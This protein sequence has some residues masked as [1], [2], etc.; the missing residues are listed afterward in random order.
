MIQH[1]NTILRRLSVELVGT[2]AGVRAAR[3]LEAREARGERDV[4]HPVRLPPG[5]PLLCC[6]SCGYD[7][8]VCT[9]DRRDV[10]PYRGQLLVWP[11]GT[12]ACRAALTTPQRREIMRSLTPARPKGVRGNITV[13]VD[14]AGW[15]VTAT[16]DDTLPFTATFAR[17]TED[18]ERE[19]S[20]VAG[21]VK[22]LALTYPRGT[23]VPTVPAAPAFP[24]S[25][26]S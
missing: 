8:D 14:L 1:S 10:R 12:P 6:A 17:R 5:A 21:V 15:T 13:A 9:C 25:V 20:R 11:W 22:A 19:R 3:T 23:E 4:V 7:T 24:V 26:A 18:G 16:S 2:P